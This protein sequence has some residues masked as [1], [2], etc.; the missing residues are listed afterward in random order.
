MSTAT[1]AAPKQRRPNMWRAMRASLLWKLLGKQKRW[2]WLSAFLFMVNALTTLQVTNVTVAMVDD[3]IVAQAVPLDPFIGK[4]LMLAI[5]A[6]IVGF[7][8]QIVTRRLSYQLEFELRTWLYRSV[9][10][11]E[12]QRLDGIASGQLITRSLTDL[13]FIERF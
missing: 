13:N 1:E 8:Q 11:A 3:A 10:S 4:V 9:H 2:V 6:L 7:I 12:L 5:L